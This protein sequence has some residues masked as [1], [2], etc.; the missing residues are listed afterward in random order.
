MAARKSES[1]C[2]SLITVDRMYWVTTLRANVK[3]LSDS[4]CSSSFDLY[5]PFAP[6]LNTF[7][8]PAGESD[9]QRPRARALRE[10]ADH[11]GVFGFE[12]P[13]FVVGV[14]AAGQ[15]RLPLL[16]Q[17]EHVV[18]WLDP[19]AGT[20]KIGLPFKRS[21]VRPARRDGAGILLP[22]RLSRHPAWSCPGAHNRKVPLRC[23]IGE[24]GTPRAPTLPPWHRWADPM[25]SVSRTSAAIWSIAPPSAGTACAGTTHHSA[26][27]S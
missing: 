19:S 11:L 4:D 1:N 3:R 10:R 21:A 17:L 9:R 5:D 26:C 7:S 16:A 18:V 25:K 14:N 23:A 27:S 22:A 24:Q 13:R 6:T 15:I 8:M 2:R 12:S 20:A